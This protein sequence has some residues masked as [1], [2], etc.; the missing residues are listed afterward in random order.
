M[1]W[2]G[3]GGW[4]EKDIGRLAPY[5]KSVSQS[6]RQKAW[7][8]HRPVCYVRVRV[9][10]ILSGPRGFYFFIAYGK[11]TFHDRKV[12]FLYS[13]PC[14][15][16][17][18]TACG[19]RYVYV[20][21]HVQFPNWPIDHWLTICLLISP[22]RSISSTGKNSALASLPRVKSPSC[23]CLLKNSVCMD[24]VTGHFRGKGCPFPRK[25]SKDSTVIDRI[26]VIAR[27]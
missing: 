5:L 27:R 21:V 25:G 14:S 7:I 1:E 11:K 6:A 4:S 3:I 8:L 2:S 15:V 10:A 9:H 16:Q 13:H 26:Q 22:C 24:T 19:A 20:H 23:F 12:C 18:L 17:I